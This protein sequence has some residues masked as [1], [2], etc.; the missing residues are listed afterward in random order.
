[1]AWSFNSRGKT[2]TS[3]APK[4][5]RS[6]NVF[7]SASETLTVA[8]SNASNQ[9]LTSSV[10]DFIPLGSNFVVVANTGAKNMSSDADIAVLASATRGGTYGLIKDDL[11]TAIDSIVV[12]A[13]YL[14]GTYGE[15]P[16]YKLFVDS[17][18]VQKKNDEF[19]ITVYWTEE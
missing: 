5:S 8:L 11:I 18:G 16:Y 1:M 4:S 14:I 3:G 2:E 6:E 15:L 13:P 12:A 19:T 9:D 10:I 7:K 17:D